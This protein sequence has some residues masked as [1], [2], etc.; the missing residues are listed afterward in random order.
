MT[1]NV[2]QL[3]LSAKRFLD[4]LQCFPL[5]GIWRLHVIT[6]GRSDVAVPHD[7]LNHFWLY[8]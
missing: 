3:W 1:N 5:L 8:S 7:R 2:T 4:H 6:E